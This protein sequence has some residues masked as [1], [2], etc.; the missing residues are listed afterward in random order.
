MSNITLRAVK[1]E[2]H[3]QL[4][5]IC[6]E[7]IYEL[8]AGRKV[9]IAPM[10]TLMDRYFTEADRHA[11][12]IHSGDALAGFA[13]VN[14]HCV[15]ESRTPH[16]SFGEF[17]IRPDY[18]RTGAGT[19]AATRL[20]D[21]HRGHWELRE[22]AG[23]DTGTAFWRRILTDYTDNNFTEMELNDERWKG[24]VQLFSNV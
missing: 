13:L 12:F 18:R 3:Q 7:Y 10:F 11:Y 6:A 16:Y 21:L 1:P 17:Y 4:K 22:M 14:S 19:T 9:D 8:Y 2:E 20:F 23:N 5:D 15:I 24:S